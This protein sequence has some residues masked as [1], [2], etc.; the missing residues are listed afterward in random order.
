MAG[1]TD[2]FVFDANGGKFSDGSTS[3]SVA[4]ISSRPI[5]EY[6][7]IDP[8]RNGYKFLRW[9]SDKNSSTGVSS[10]SSISDVGAEATQILYAI[11]QKEGVAEQ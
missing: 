3:L 10:N 4:A 2:T 1:V 11:W 8:I 6:C 5:K 7:P 9:S